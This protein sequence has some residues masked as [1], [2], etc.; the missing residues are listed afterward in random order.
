MSDAAQCP[1]G[2]GLMREAWKQPRGCST[3]TAVGS[4]LLRAAERERGGLGCPPTP[5]S[6]RHPCSTEVALGRS[7]CKRLFYRMNRKKNDLSAGVL[8]AA[9]KQCIASLRLSPLAGR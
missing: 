2:C 5:R 8:A 1:G 6:R 3:G 7:A 4:F 9:P